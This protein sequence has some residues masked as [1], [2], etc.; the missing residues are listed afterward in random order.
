MSRGATAFEIFL[1]VAR[2]LK[3]ISATLGFQGAE[4]NSR[5]FFQVQDIGMIQREN[6]ADS[7]SPVP[8]PSLGLLQPRPVKES[9]RAEALLP[10]TALS[11]REKQIVAPSFSRGLLPVETDLGESACL[12]LETG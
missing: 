8:S 1:G 7:E 9:K 10:R 5:A 2:R 12:Q 3:L 4:Q 6:L 11:C